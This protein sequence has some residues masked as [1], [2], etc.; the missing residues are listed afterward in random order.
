M[1]RLHGPNTILLYGIVSD[2][3][4]LR[5]RLVNTLNTNPDQA[6]WQREVSRLL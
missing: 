5:Q 3:Q 2:N 4:R 1:V 6:V